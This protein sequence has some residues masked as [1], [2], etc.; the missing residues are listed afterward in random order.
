MNKFSKEILINEY[1]NLPS[2][3][4]VLV[5]TKNLGNVLKPN[6]HDMGLRYCLKNDLISKERNK[7]FL[8]ISGK[9][10]LSILDEYD[11]SR[12]IKI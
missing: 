6:D 11:L 10:A 7:Y 2:I 4:R 12:G 1:L 9:D 3:K 8:T 5:Q